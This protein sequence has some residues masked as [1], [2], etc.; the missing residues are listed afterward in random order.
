MLPSSMAS[1]VG[2]GLCF[3]GGFSV[4]VYNGYTCSD[5]TDRDENFFLGVFTKLEQQSPEDASAQVVSRG[6][7][8]RAQTSELWS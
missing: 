5:L 7:E 1:H 8:G 4:F 3:H 6:S 2:R